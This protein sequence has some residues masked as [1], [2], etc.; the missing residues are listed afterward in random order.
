MSPVDAL[1]MLGSRPNSQRIR[2]LSLPWHLDDREEMAVATNFPQLERLRIW[3][4][5]LESTSPLMR[6]VHLTHLAVST[7]SITQRA[8]GCESI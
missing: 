8:I 3:L 5:T 1:E 7:K 4:D 2:E 6:L